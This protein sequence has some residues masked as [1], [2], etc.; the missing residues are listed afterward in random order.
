LLVYKGILDGIVYK[1]EVRVE[2]GVVI[3]MSGSRELS[4]AQEAQIKKIKDCIAWRKLER[5]RIRHEMCVILSGCWG[6]RYMPLD[7]IKKIVSY[8]YIKVNCPKEYV[9]TARYLSSSESRIE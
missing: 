8:G 7:V 2:C 9:Y 6:E 5:K 3:K 4:A 1:I